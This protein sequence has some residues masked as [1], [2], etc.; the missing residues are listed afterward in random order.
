LNVNHPQTF[1]FDVTQPSDRGYLVALS[2]E[3]D[4]AGVPA[5]SE[6]FAAFSD[7]ASPRVVVDLSELRFIDSTGIRA[8]MAAARAIGTNGGLMT[9]TAPRPN[10]Q[11]VFDIVRLGDVILIEQSPVPSEIPAQV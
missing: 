9:L 7:L 8:L 3:L 5:L 11:R 1:G 2:G 6:R 10:V 4:L